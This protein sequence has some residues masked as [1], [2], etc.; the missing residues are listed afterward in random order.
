MSE[1]SSPHPP[2]T[3]GATTPTLWFAIAIW[4]V[5]SLGWMARD[6]MVPDGDEQGH[7]GAAELFLSDLSSGNLSGFIQ[8]FY[9]EQMGEYPQAFTAGV[10]L[11][12]WLMDG[13]Q[14]GRVSV[15]GICLISL[16][17]AA[18]AVGR[19]ARRYTTTDTRDL[20][21]AIATILV[22]C[23]P[24]AN[25]V[26]RHFM[27]EGALI[28]A[29]C[30]T[31][32]MAH[33]FVEYPT[34]W[35]GVLLGI[36]MGLGFLTK[37]TFVLMVALPLVWLLSRVRMYN[38][39]A[40]CT[41]ILVA[42]GVA[43]PWIVHNSSEQMSY[44]LSSWGGHGDASLWEHVLYYPATT[45]W[46]GLGPILALATVVAV[47]RLFRVHDKRVLILG[48]IWLIGG[49][50]LL[51]L[52]PKK[53]PR[54]LAPLL[55]VVAI[56]IATAMVSSRMRRRWII[57]TLSLAFGWLLLTSTTPIPLS[58]TPD[59]IDPGCPQSWLRPPDNRDLGLER[60]AN[61]L[62]DMPPGP[63]LLIGAPSIPCQVQ[64]T[65]DWVEHLRPYLRRSGVDRAVHQ[66]PELAHS[67][68][69][70]WTGGPGEKIDVP[71]LSTSVVIRAKLAP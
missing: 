21:Q 60:T 37:Q 16:V 20:A 68:I 36:F 17:I 48:A 28:A 15:R 9:W 7:I 43:G 27:P 32:L 3:P 66:D 56:W 22:L 18:I 58:L 26:T 49:M 55:P 33:R 40:I 57:S 31:M 42:G 25:G 12:W 62:K 52:V 45:V 53:Y 24:L 13:G 47:F 71:A 4:T 64:T 54:L 38:F 46:L 44:G 59:S 6:K 50:V 39:P 70:D 63:I 61:A 5:G 19:I 29:V 8:R 23:I 30:V 1:Q 65:H 35:R 2:P 51:T 34:L 41:A 10:G 67:S 14:P 11:W 69:I